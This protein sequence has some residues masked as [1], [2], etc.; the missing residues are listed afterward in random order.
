MALNISNRMLK[1]ATIRTLKRFPTAAMFILALTIALFVMIQIEEH[2]KA[3]TFY[4]SA[5]ILLSTLLQLWKEETTNKRIYIATSIISHILLIIDA[6]IIHF[7]SMNDGLTMLFAQ[8]SIVLGL[9]LGICFL[10]FWKEKSDVASWHFVKTLIFGTVISWFV[11][12]I[13]GCGIMLLLAGFEPLFN[14]E[15]GWKT[16]VSITVIFYITLPLLIFLSRIPHGEDKF[17]KSTEVAPF[18][19][20]SIRYLFIPLVI[21]YVAVMYV[22]VGKTIIQVEL[23]NGAVSWLVTVMMLGFICIEFLLYP[24]MRGDARKFEQIIVRWLPIVML[25]PLILMT[26]GLIRRFSDYGISANRLYMLTLN[27]WF[28]IVCFGLFLYRAKRIHWISL[29]FGIILLITSAQPANYSNIAKWSIK[30]EITKF[31]SANAPQHLP[32]SESQLKA[33]LKTLNKEDAEYIYGKLE[34]INSNHSDYSKEWIK[35]MYLPNKYEHFID[36]ANTDECVIA[37]NY[38]DIVNIPEGYSKMEA[39]SCYRNQLEIKLVNAT[40]AEIQAETNSKLIGRRE[41]KINLKVD[42]DKLEQVSNDSTQIILHTNLPDVVLVP[43]YIN[44]TING[45]KAETGSMTGYVFKK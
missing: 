13:V 17:C 22:Y 1:E 39:F 36:S 41:S 16:Y 29:S 3:V 5:G 6:V 35:D 8:G 31:M 40:T 9:L 42:F 26:V 28:Y 18:L 4:F 2:N 21:A 43:T 25:P 34:Y 14:I 20:G 7:S 37:Y 15:I 24:S 23:P 27:I 19:T 12:G 30:K 45:K 32:M 33:W 44:L 38:D 10:P 11:A